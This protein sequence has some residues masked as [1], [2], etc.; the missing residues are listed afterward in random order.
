[1]FMKCWENLWNT[2][3]WSVSSFAALYFEVFSLLI[4]FQYLV[5]FSNNLVASLL[6]KVCKFKLYFFLTFVYFIILK[7]KLVYKVYQ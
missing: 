4:V 1:M 3:L 7:S 2:S 6:L 5:L